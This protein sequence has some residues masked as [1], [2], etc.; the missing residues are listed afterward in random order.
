MG[1]SFVLQSSVVLGYK[2]KKKKR[3]INFGVLLRGYVADKIVE[4]KLLK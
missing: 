2:K 1:I 4:H 3:L